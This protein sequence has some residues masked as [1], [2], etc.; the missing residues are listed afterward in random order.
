MF[1]SEFDNLEQELSASLS[2]LDKPCGC[3]EKGAESENPFA[4]FSSSDDLMGE[5]EMALS[6]LDGGML[7]PEEALEFASISD[8]GGAGLADII[9]VLE[10]NPGLKITLSV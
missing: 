2:A 3:H 8:S 7:S 10:Q 5:L 4:E 1:M 9:S 6:S